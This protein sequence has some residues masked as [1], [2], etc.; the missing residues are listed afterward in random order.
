MKVVTYNI[1]H[2]QDFSVTTADDA[3]VN[4]E[5][6]AKYLADLDADVLLL[7]E[8]FIKSTD[9][10]CFDKQTSKVNVWASYPYCAEGIGKEFSWATIGN[11]FFTRYPIV[12]SE[13][14]PVL[15]PT[16]DERREGENEWYEDRVIVSLTLNAD[17]KL[18][19]VLG[20]H[21]GLNGLEQERMIQALC[22]VIN[23]T[24]LPIIVLGDF[25]ARPHTSILAPLYER[26]VSCADATA[27]TEHTFPS[28]APDRTLDYIFVSKDFQLNNFTVRKEVLSDHKALSATVTF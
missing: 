5:K 12:K 21:F 28:F 10:E 25:N 7:N 11:V 16:E 24:D 23:Q 26:L 15:A 2:C 27:N 14:I 6:Y 20:T 9:T 4:I 3:P 1:S 18:F 22:S 19:R 13:C 17:G 8:V